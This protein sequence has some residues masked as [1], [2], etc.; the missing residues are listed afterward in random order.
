MDAL[1]FQQI[2]DSK[3]NTAVLKVGPQTSIQEALKQLGLRHLIHLPITS[4]SNSSKIVSIVSILDIVTYLTSHSGDS[5]CLQHPVERCL[6]LSADEENYLMWERDSQDLVKE[7]LVKFASGLHRALVTTTDGTAVSIVGQTDILRFIFNNKTQL[8]VDL[9]TSITRVAQKKPQNRP[10]VT[11]NASQSAL[12]GFTLMSTNGVPVVPVLTPSNELVAVLSPK[13]LR[14]FNTPNAPSLN[15]L[16]RPVLEF[17][18]INDLVR[19][20]VRLEGDASLSD[21]INLLLHH[22]QHHVWIINGQRQLVAVVSH[23]DIIGFLTL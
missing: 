10:L 19:P 2:L 4:H 17:L 11:M 15:D 5:T 23:S 18:C 3:P 16:N 6:S 7:T 21:A 20:L 12:D 1:T 14:A 22:H 8:K 9:S 13:D